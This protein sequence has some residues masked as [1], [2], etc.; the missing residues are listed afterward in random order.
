MLKNT[1][2][3]Q[4]NIQMS[5]PYF[6]QQKRRR[7]SNARLENADQVFVLLYGLHIMESIDEIQVEGT[8]IDISHNR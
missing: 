4:V 8:H 5:V 3:R 7:K 6:E 2:E 1:N